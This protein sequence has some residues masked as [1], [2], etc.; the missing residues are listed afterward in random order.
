[1][2][3]KRIHE[4]AKEYGMSGKELAGKLRD[5]GFTHV[6]SHMTALDEFEEL[7]V[8]GVLEAHGYKRGGAPE[9]PLDAELGA[10][11]IRRKKKKKPGEAEVEAPAEAAAPVEPVAAPEPTPAPEPE[12]EVAPAASPAAEAPAPAP[13][14][15]APA[16]EPAAAEPAAAEPVVAESEVQVEVEAPAEAPVAE[17]TPAATFALTRFAD[18]DRPAVDVPNMVPQ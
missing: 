3:K 2:S 15:E 1:M 13:E 8:Q 14:R 4:L 11:L 17:P 6:K 16:E 10:G 18:A 12:V 5:L 9:D 7:S